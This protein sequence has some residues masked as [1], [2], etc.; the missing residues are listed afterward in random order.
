M[1]TEALRPN[2]AHQPLNTTA[3]PPAKPSKFTALG[4][5]LDQA[6]IRSNGDVDLSNSFISKIYL[7]VNGIGFGRQLGGIPENAVAIHAYRHN[8]TTPWSAPFLGALS[9]LGES[10]CGL[11][12]TY[13]AITD[14][15]P[16]CVRKLA[17]EWNAGNLLNDVKKMGHIFGDELNRAKEELSRELKIATA[18][19][20]NQC[21]YLCLGIAQTMH[22]TLNFIWSLYETVQKFSALIHGANGW[23]LAAGLTTPLLHL[24]AKVSGAAAGAFYFIRGMCIVY[25]S[26]KSKEV[27][28]DFQKKFNEAGQIEGT[29]KQKIANVMFFMKQEEDFANGL[30]KVKDEGVDNLGTEYLNR[31]FSTAF[32]TKIEEGTIYTAYGKMDENEK[33]S[34]YDSNRKEYNLKDRIEYLKAVDKGI[35]SEQLKHKLGKV[36]G[37]AMIVAAVLTILAVCVVTG[38]FAPLIIGLVACIIFA[39]MEYAFYKYDNSEAFEQWRDSKYVMSDWLQKLVIEA[40]EEDFSLP[41]GAV[42]EDSIE[43]STEADDEDFIE[44][45][46]EADDEDFIEL[47]TEADD[48]DFINQLMT[49]MEESQMESEEEVD[50][51]A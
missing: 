50:K 18:Q 16:G 34:S 7:F 32:L 20:V 46:T 14:T 11:G 38:P 19:L 30:E 17:K 45:S 33:L 36:I 5:A 9:S 27:V 2:G 3:S 49:E 22:G 43:L 42:E 48:E 37:I 29:T 35:F 51:S 21:F 13:A 44:L 4:A 28:D 47:S 1:T 26:Q 41:P 40:N 8:T 25:R 10:F 23:H 24:V 6:H 15:I 12:N 31:R 39:V